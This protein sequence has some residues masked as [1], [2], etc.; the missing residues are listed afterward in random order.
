MIKAKKLIDVVIGCR[1]L[2]SIIV[3]KINNDMRNYINIVETYE[4]SS[5]TG[6]SEHTINCTG[7]CVVGDKV[8]F[9][10]ATFTGSFRNAKFSGFELI[11]GEIIKDSYG[12]AKQQHTF[13]LRLEDGSTKRI[14]GRNL[15]ANGTWRQKWDDE[16]KRQDALDEK[17]GRGDKAR[18]DRAIRK[19]QPL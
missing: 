9:E 8:A 1:L 4:T 16:D 13:T 5:F 19:N 10:K 12:A 2:D 11:K 17:H 3:V 14:K 7:D 6:D 18:E 15:Y